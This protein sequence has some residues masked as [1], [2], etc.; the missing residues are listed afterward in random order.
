[1]RRAKKS[2]ESRA[3]SPEQKS[4]P[5]LVTLPPGHRRAGT[6]AI[7]LLLALLPTAFSGDSIT[8][9]VQDQTYV[10]VGFDTLDP[11]PHNLTMTLQATGANNEISSSW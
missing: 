5:H 3:E 9:L 7:L 11:G 6:L 8:Q 10:G 1:M 4:P 2:P